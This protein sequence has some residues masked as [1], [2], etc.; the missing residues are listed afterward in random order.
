MVRQ[1]KNRRGGSIVN[2][3]CLLFFCG[4]GG[5][6]VGGK[7]VCLVISFFIWLNTIVMGCDQS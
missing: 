5:W 3:V 4:G 2:G 6:G 7:G 1:T